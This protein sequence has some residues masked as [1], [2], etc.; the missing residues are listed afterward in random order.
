MPSWMPIVARGVD[1]RGVNVTSKNCPGRGC[2]HLPNVWRNRM[3]MPAS[4]KLRLPP[5]VLASASSIARLSTPV[6]PTVVA[7]PVHFS[8]AVLVDWLINNPRPGFDARKA[9][10]KR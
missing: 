3:S 4:P 5:A 7:H 9:D 8:A 10:A 2:C 1:P 6:S